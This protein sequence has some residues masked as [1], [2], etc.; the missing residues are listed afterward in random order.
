MEKQNHAKKI[1]PFQKK[2]L[3][4]NKTQT[5]D[6]K[7]NQTPRKKKTFENENQPRYKKKKLKTTR[8]KKKPI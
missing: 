7:L 2:T 6:M 8:K 3:L 4:K 5:F 1:N